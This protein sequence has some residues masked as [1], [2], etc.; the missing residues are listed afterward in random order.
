M[1]FNELKSQLTTALGAANADSRLTN[2]YFY[3][4]AQKHI[5]WLLKQESDKMLLFSSDGIWQSLDCVDVIEVPKVDPCCRYQGPSCTIRRTKD[6]LPEIY[7]DAL[8]VMVRSVNSIDSSKSLRLIKFTE[9]ERKQKNPDSKYD[10]E[11]YFFFKDG[12]FYFPNISWKL[13]SITAYFKDDISHINY[14]SADDSSKCVDYFN[15][16]VRV[17]HYLEG[18]V[19]DACLKELLETVARVQE[20][21]QPD[22][23]T[24]NRH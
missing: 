6:K 23:N 1:T 2:R 13:V 5:G 18:R 11:S 3:S 12:Y 19:V 14:C 22:K 16:P 7:E 8:G 4:L 10:K 9:W 17:P 15:Q 20:D 24:L 21:S